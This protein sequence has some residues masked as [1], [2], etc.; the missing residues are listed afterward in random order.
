MVNQWKAIERN[1]YLGVAICL[2]ILVIMAS[3]SYQGLVRVQKDFQWVTQTREVLLN[4]SYFLSSL[5]DAEM[6]QREYLLTGKEQYLMPYQYIEKGVEYYFTDLRTIAAGN[7]AQQ[8]KLDVFEKLV[9]KK[10][11]E[12]RQL[13]ELQKA[14]GAA[15]AKNALLTGTGKQIMNDIQILVLGMDQ[16]ERVLLDERAKHIALRIKMDAVVKAALFILILITAFLVISRINY[17]R[18]ASK[19]AEQEQIRLAN[20]D[21]LTELVNR[22]RFFEIFEREILRAKMK[23]YPLALILLDIDHF[24]NI[25]DTYGHIAGDDILK[26]IG[27]ILKDNLYPLDVAARYGGEEFIILVPETSFERVSKTAEKLRRTI[28]E[29]QW[30]ISDNRISITTSIGVVML[31]PNNITDCQDMVKKADEALYTAKKKGRNCTVCWNQVCV[32][33]KTVEPQVQDFHELQTKISS[34]TRRLRIQALGTVSAFEKAMSIAIKDPYIAHHS[35]HVRIYATA[36]AK[37][38]SLAD[39][40]IE[41]IGTA[42]VLH[43]LGKMGIPAYLFSKTEP[44]TQQE[45]SIIKQH[46]ITSVQILAPIGVF[47]HELQIIRHHH[48]RFDG[49]GYP[50]GLKGREIEIGARVVAIADTFDAITSDRLY[51]KRQTYEEALKE[52]CSCSETQ[53]DPD[54][55]EAFLNAAEKHYSQWPLSAFD[56]SVG[57]TSEPIIAKA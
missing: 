17:W 25:N 36:T 32:D 55:V 9:T 53:F 48:E 31:E 40:L 50:D 18:A 12:L 34:L 56:L 20:T 3:V 47:N 8:K 24:K 27:R 38:L 6:G 45:W 54:V 30:N 2:M 33:E 13:I 52:I 11:T 10:L 51:R 1:A 14:K 39:D 16:D 44:L 7:T 5:K 21:G 35:K 23:S 41:R 15:A 57:S 43:D 37:E 28:N 22:R 49:G 42:A 46:P 4:L 29:W 19:K 26:Q